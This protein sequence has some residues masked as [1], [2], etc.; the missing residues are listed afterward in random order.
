LT[1][2]YWPAASG[3]PL[4]EAGRADR[5][6][7]VHTAMGMST[8][9]Y[10]AAGFTHARP[11]DTAT[12]ITIAAARARSARASRAS[13]SPAIRPTR[14][15]TSN[16]TRVASTASSRLAAKM[17]TA[18]RRPGAAPGVGVCASSFFSCSVPRH[19]PGCPPRDPSLPVAG[20][21]NDNGQPRLCLTAEAGSAGRGGFRRQ[22]GRGRTKYSE[23]NGRGQRA[24][25]RSHACSR[26]LTRGGE[27]QPCDLVLLAAQDFT[28][29]PIARVHLPARIPLGF[30]GS[31]IPDQ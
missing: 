12:T 28:A 5:C 16:I 6:S 29:E 20:E 2:G 23:Q 27:R 17:S 18:S 15:P 24:P 22:A 13:I 14:R 9:Q 3:R 10:L 25:A 19:P 11:T 26:A 4:G 7:A 30:H 31:W 1:A 21:G 8:Q